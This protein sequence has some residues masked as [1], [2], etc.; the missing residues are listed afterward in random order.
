MR[1]SYVIALALCFSF[2]TTHS[3]T[4]IGVDG[5][6]DALLAGGP[7]YQ[8]YNGQIVPSWSGYESGREPEFHLTAPP[9]TEYHVWFEA[10][11]PF[12][13]G[14]CNRSVEWGCG[15]LTPIVHISDSGIAR[16][17]PY[18]QL[19]SPD[20]D[21]GGDSYFAD[22]KCYA[23]NAS[24]NDT[25]T[26]T[27]RLVVSYVSYP[28]LGGLSRLMRNQEYSL[29][30][31]STDR[32]YLVP[33]VTHREQAVQLG[34]RVSANAGERVRV[35]FSLPTNLINGLDSIPC[36]FTATSLY[37][38][39]SGKYFNPSLPETLLVGE[40]C[41]VTLKLGISLNVPEV[42]IGD[43][44]LGKI[45][46]TSTQLDSPSVPIVEY[47]SYG[48]RLDPVPTKIRLFQNYPNPFNPVTRIEYQIGQVTA[49][50][51]R[52]F[53]ILGEQVAEL[54]N[55]TRQAGTHQ[56]IFSGD[57]LASGVYLYQLEANGQTEQKKMLLIR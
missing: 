39:E 15:P 12:L 20:W 10:L 57:G 16:I 3:Q 36:W 17:R 48:V 31:D 22:L 2:V 11:S 6:I 35:E 43:V 49:V 46:L 54:V 19:R 34:H 23:V 25:L 52:V 41:S 45:T 21:Q 32:G 13:V 27:G 38:Q 50:R 1:F 40:N 29:I 44:F 26:A 28:S 14:S 7:T 24:S 30:P 4:L 47:L 51:L 18:L 56:A 8:V 9:G 53:D 33:M 37:H 55:E 5:R 42:V